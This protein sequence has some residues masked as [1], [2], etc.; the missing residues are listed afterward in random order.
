MPPKEKPA[1]KW[2]HREPPS[3]F[4]LD[5]HLHFRVQARAGEESVEEGR[6]VTMREV[7]TKALEEYLSK[8]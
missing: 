8:R 2:P 5:K 6:K 1:P 7:V 4:R 3:S